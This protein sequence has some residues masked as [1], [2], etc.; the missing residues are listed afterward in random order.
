MKDFKSFTEMMEDQEGARPEEFAIPWKDSDF[1]IVGDYIA[2]YA[3]S[4]SVEKA[5]KFAEDNNLYVLTETIE[6][7]E[8]D[9]EWSYSR[10]FS[11]VN[12][13]RFFFTKKND[14]FCFAEID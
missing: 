10:G 8:E 2:V 1:E 11:W 3:H 6:D 14:D 13:E 9:S 12:R 4:Q 5:K 7:G